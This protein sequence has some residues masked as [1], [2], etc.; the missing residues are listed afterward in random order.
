MQIVCFLSLSHPALLRRDTVLFSPHHF[1]HVIRG[2]L[3]TSTRVHE[4][5]EKLDKLDI[6][7]KWYLY[8]YD[9]FDVLKVM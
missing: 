3:K 6:S 7:M 5:L 1:P 9:L 8:I 4:Q 2:T